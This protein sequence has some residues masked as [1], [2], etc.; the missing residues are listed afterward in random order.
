[1]LLFSLQVQKM[2]DLV[3]VLCW[4]LFCLPPAGEAAGYRLSPQDVIEISVW[5]HEDL[6]R[7]LTVESD[8]WISYPLA[9]RVQAGDRT[10]AELSEELIRRIS[11][12][13]PNP[14][15]TVTV[16]EYRGLSVTVLGSVRR[17]GHYS[18]AGGKNLLDVLAEAGG[19]SD[20]GNLSRVR[21]IRNGHRETVNLK[22]V[23]EGERE[24]LVNL[25]PGDTIYVP[26][27]R[28]A[29]LDMRNMQFV[30]T[31]GVLALQAIVLAS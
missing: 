5:Q 16:R 26:R 3:L 28:F 2:K 25:E 18:I 12:H 31:L 23:L 15:I 19:V 29:W 20:G 8:G 30:L 9:G 22:P 27:K 7:V 10:I 14:Q 24:L 4:L 21:V 11:Q 1:M 17:S 6:S 13:I